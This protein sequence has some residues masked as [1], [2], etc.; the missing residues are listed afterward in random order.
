MRHSPIHTSKYNT[1]LVFGFIMHAEEGFT[2]PDIFSRSVNMW[3]NLSPEAILT[4]A[5]AFPS[6]YF[7]YSGERAIH[8]PPNAPS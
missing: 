3:I 6:F 5:F 2:G 7:F 4:G 8:L 1:G